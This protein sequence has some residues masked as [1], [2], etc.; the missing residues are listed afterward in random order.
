MQLSCAD[1]E[2]RLSHGDSQLLL[3]HKTANQIYIL[4]INL[5]VYFPYKSKSYTAF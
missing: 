4:P 3:Q 5:S 1:S 2:E